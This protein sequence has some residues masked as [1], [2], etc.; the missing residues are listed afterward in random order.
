MDSLI[1][2]HFSDI[3]QDILII[4]FYFL[5]YR[6][7]KLEYFCCQQDILYITTGTRNSIQQ[8]KNNTIKWGNFCFLPCVFIY[9]GDFI[10]LLFFVG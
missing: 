7:N 2:L 8:K 5:Y 3:W 1:I 10:F 9:S 6:L 4:S